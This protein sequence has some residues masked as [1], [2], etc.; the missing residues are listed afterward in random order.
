MEN[1]NE[2][3]LT[4]WLT[5]SSVVNNERIVSSIPFNEAHVCNLLYRQRMEHPDVYLTATELCA[6]TRMLKSQMNKVL[7]SLERQNMISR[8]R[9]PDDRRKA[10]I[11]LVDENLHRFEAVHARS[12]ALVDRAIERLGADTAAQLAELLLRAA[13]YV[14]ETLQT[15]GEHGHSC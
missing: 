15:S 9:A 10:Y 12:I 11:R 5:M 8:F 7:A 6:R 2:K 14:D 3:L 4:A 1:L 13:N